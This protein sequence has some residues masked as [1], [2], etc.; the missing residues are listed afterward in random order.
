[1]REHIDWQKPSD[2]MP[3]DDM[4]VLLHLEDEE[5]PVWPGYHDGEEGWLL[6]DA[7]PAPK[8]LGWADMPKGPA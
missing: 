2:R 6:A 5:W 4:T 3:D 7:M 1:M 8:V